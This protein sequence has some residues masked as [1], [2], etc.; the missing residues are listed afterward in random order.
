MHVFVSDDAVTNFQNIFIIFWN[1]SPVDCFLVIFVGFDLMFLFLISWIASE[2]AH[3]EKWPKQIHSNTFL[4]IQ[5][6][7][8]E[9]TVH[10][11]SGWNVFEWTRLSHSSATNASYLLIHSMYFYW[12][13]DFC[14]HEK[15]LYI[16]HFVPTT[17]FVEFMWKCNRNTSKLVRFMIAIC[18][19]RI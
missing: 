7:L 1:C 16:C 12:I 13:V 9:I 4:T 8:T 10:F 3:S 5:C 14:V 15:E 18:R 17:R 6:G 19:F 11:G 2:R